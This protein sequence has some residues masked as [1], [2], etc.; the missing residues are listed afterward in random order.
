M[1]GVAVLLTGFSGAGKSTIT[2]ALVAELE[3][4]GTAVTVRMPVLETARADA[5]RSGG[6]EIIP[7][8]VVSKG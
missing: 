7:M 1:T 5:P 2:D 3:A 4:E 8:P 6:A